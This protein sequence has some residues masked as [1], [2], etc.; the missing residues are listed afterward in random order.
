YQYDAASR[1]IQVAQ[2]GL[3]VGL[4]YDNANRRTSLT[5]PNGTNM[6]YSYDNASRVTAITHNGPSG[7]MESLSYVYDAAGN[8]ISLAR[9]NGTATNLPTAVQAAYDA[10][11]EQV[12]FNSLPATFDANGNQTTSTDASGTTTY[13]WD[14]RNRL[15][16]QT[17]PGLSASFSYDALGRRIGKTINSVTTSYLYDGNDIVQEIG[18]S[19]V[20][21][22]Y[23]RSRKIDEPF[24]RQVST[25]NEY[26]HTDAL[27]S[28]L[29]LSNAAGATAVSYSYETFGKTTITG[30][31]SNSFQYTGRENDGTGLYFYRARY[32]NAQL[33]RFTTE[34]PTRLRGGFNF[35]S[36]AEN[37]PVFFTDP[38]GFNKQPQ[39]MCELTQGRKVK[40]MIPCPD[41]GKLP[42]NIVPGPAPGPVCT[43]DSECFFTCVAIALPGAI[44]TVCG[45]CVLFGSAAPATCAVCAAVV[46]AGV[47]YTC[48]QLCQS[49]INC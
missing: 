27:G 22:S 24:V 6:S 43:V 39:R 37:N 35:Y 9:T 5:Y 42:S 3:V 20:G 30:T 16:A 12:A 26:Y 28:S 1:L 8:R 13:T 15:V 38:L 31:S 21:A 44:A 46:S 7:L 36:Y 45:D 23:V 18:G 49:C 17:G 2:A 19:A 33:Q 4:G 34:D 32:Y 11:N 48:K 25:G 40:V 29:A 47:S 41:D 10:A 14:A